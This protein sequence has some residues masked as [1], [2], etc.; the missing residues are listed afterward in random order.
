M[1]SSTNSTIEYPER[2]R[3][4]DLGWDLAQIWMQ[5]SVDPERLEADYSLYKLQFDVSKP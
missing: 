3:R 2:E 1:D 5:L 4:D